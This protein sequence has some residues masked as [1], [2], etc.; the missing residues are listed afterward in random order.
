LHYTLLGFWQS[1]SVRNFAFQKVLGNG[2][3]SEKYTVIADVALARKFRITLQELPSLC[4]RLLE[5]RPE[6]S[7]SGMILITDADLCVHAAANLAIAQEDAAKRG[8]RS[9]RGAIAVA[10]RTQKH[11][12]LQIPSPVRRTDKS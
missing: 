7:P 12:A 3:A 5:A 10:A 1:D 8:L 2:T 4:A 11:L 9:R 6:D